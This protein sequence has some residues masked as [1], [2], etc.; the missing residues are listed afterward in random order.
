[1]GI[2]NL[3]TYLLQKC[4]TNSIFKTSIK[5][6]SGKSIAIDIS[7]YLYKYLNQNV[8]LENIYVMI[9]IFKCN[10]INPIFVFDGKSPIEKW[11]T[12]KERYEMRK[13]A[14]EEYLKL[15]TELE[16]IEI[17]DSIK[18]EKLKEL[19]LIKQKTTKITKEDIAKVKELIQALGC[20]YID[21]PGE[22]DQLCAYLVNKGYAYGC[23][24]DDMDMLLYGCPIIIRN[25]NLTDATI[26]IYNTENI[27]KDID[28]DME[29]FR[30]I[31][32]LAGTDYNKNVQNVSIDLN[33]S[34]HFYRKFC[35]QN[36]ESDFYRW[37]L[38]YFPDHIKNLDRLDFVYN[39]FMLSNFDFEYLPNNIKSTNHKKIQE[40]LEPEGFIFI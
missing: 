4:S 31:I 20:Q 39:L 35:E 26:T 22:A 32:I 37:I 25:L 3:N 36:E 38:K 21:A 8:L 17:S 16:N 13:S 5:T 6:I 24:S 14:E 2:K 7:I 28:I 34:I 9:H 23:L 11:D 33:E 29:N 19:N 40:L 1:M 10:N 15:K 12:I 18:K 30:K 27:L